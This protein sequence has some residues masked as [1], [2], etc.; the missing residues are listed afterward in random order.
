MKSTECCIVIPIYHEDLFDYEVM[1]L[2]QC[3]KI[4]NSN[5]K[6]V[7]IYPNNINIFDI[8]NKYNINIKYLEDYDNIRYDYRYFDSIEAFNQLLFE[9]DLYSI[10]N[11]KK[12]KYT[13]LYELDAFIFYDNL[14]YWIDKNYDFIGSFG[15]TVN[16]N[17][18]EDDTKFLPMNGGFSLRKIEYC[19][20]RFDTIWGAKLYGHMWEDAILSYNND[21]IKP[22]AHETFDFC[23]SY[24]Y[25][26]S[27][28]L[29][30]FKLPMAVHYYTCNNKMYNYC[31]NIF[32]N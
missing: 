19:L 30:N 4:L 13:L 20:N 10:L 24:N 16:I 21:M 7:F 1:S 2:K 9:S 8:L 29:N 14:K 27:Y 22:L 18:L 28:I 3:I 6:I 11:D 12:Y 26:L 5:Y 32:N 15:F 23:W 31:K 17:S 25:Q